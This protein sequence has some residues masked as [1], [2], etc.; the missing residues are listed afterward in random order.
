MTIFVL[1]RPVILCHSPS[2]RFPLQRWFAVALGSLPLGVVYLLASLWSNGFLAMGILLANS[3]NII[4]FRTLR[5]EHAANRLPEIE[6][7]CFLRS[8][9]E[10]AL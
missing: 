2:W 3:S 1:P 8:P 9:R 10:S 7:E 6:T 5:D 4:L